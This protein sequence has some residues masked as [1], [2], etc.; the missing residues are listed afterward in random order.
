MTTL[1]QSNLYGV[2]ARDKPIT[3]PPEEEDDSDYDEDESKRKKRD[4]ENENE[5]TE[6]EAEDENTEPNVKFTI[7]KAL[8]GEIDKSKNTG[9]LI[10]ISFCAIITIFNKMYDEPLCCY[11]WRYLNKYLARWILFNLPTTI[12]KLTYVYCSNS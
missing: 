4:T 5:N 12:S 7:T 9:I 1:H 6:G 2:L 11:F 3:F 8:F 10:T